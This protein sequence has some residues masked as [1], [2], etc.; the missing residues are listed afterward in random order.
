MEKPHYTDTA[1]SDSVG[2]IEIATIRRT[3]YTPAYGA[4]TMLFPLLLTSAREAYAATVGEAEQKNDTTAHRRAATYM[5]GLLL[6][7]ETFLLAQT[8]EIRGHRYHLDFITG[9]MQLWTHLFVVFERSA[10]FFNIR[11]EGSISEGIFRVHN[12]ATDRALLRITEEELMRPHFFSEELPFM[13]SQTQ[14]G[15]G[16]SDSSTSLELVE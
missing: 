2:F 9:T 11:V 15:P 12:A 5:A 10:S 7:D 6:A 16:L 4:P 3:F 13:C 8:A 14:S 1:K